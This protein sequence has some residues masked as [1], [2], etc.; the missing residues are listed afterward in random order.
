MRAPNRA[1][2]IIERRSMSV[3][4]FKVV[5]RLKCPLRGRGNEDGCS[6]VCY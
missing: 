3:P 6:V 1:L 2:P 5:I 4:E